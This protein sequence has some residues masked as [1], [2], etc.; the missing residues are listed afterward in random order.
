MSC[1]TSCLTLCRLPDRVKFSGHQ[2][3]G[4]HHVLQGMH[5]RSVRPGEAARPAVQSSEGPQRAVMQSRSVARK[6]RASN[7][8]ST[9][10]TLR[11]ILLSSSRPP[12]FR[13]R[14]SHCHPSCSCRVAMGRVKTLV[15]LSETVHDALQ[16]HAHPT[17]PPPQEFSNAQRL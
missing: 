5:G 3:C 9:C 11:R 4:L 1:A 2:L 6:P 16:W 15:Q 13:C 10:S 17:Y 8:R 14:Q 7:L 12:S